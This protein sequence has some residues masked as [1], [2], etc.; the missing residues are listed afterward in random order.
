MSTPLIKIKILLEDKLEIDGTYATGSQVSLINSKLVKIKKEKSE[1]I[2]KIFLKT[3]NGVTHTKGLITIKLKIFDI[4]KQVDVFI[5]ERD[6]F[7]DFLIGLDI[8]EKFKLMQDENLQILQKKEV[9]TKDIERKRK[10]KIDTT[11][12]IKEVKVNF[13]EHVDEEE[14]KIKLDHL[15]DTKKTTIEKLIEKYSTVFAKNKYDVGTVKEYEAR[16]DLLIDKYCSKRPYR[17]TIEDK[18]EIEN[19]V[20]RLLENN[21]IEESYSPFAAPVT[22]AFK[23]DENKRSRFCIDFRELNKIIIPQAQPFPLIDDLIIKTRNCKYF[24]TLDINSAFWSIPLRI[25]DRKKTG[26]VTQEGHF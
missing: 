9:K 22:L 4:E 20:A 6:D 24:T 17:C 21:L 26:F 23:R 13:N 12:G 25:E 15:D 19:Q 1:D 7:E 10:E 11:D 14:F 18:K 3:I 8:I 16:I 5:V 2:N